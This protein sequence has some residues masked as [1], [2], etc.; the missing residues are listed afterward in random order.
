MYVTCFSGVRD[1]EG[2]DPGSLGTTNAA[3]NG[4]VENSDRS[5]KTKD[6]APVEDRSTPSTAS[7]T[8]A[9]YSRECLEI[10]LSK[11]DETDLHRA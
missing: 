11:G 2:L 6:A 10:A 1:L 8:T 4:S 7:I 5:R 3:K 9:Y